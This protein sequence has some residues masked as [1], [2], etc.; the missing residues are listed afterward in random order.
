M[1]LGVWSVS[2]ITAL[3]KF[4]WGLSITLLETNLN[5]SFTIDKIN[6]TPTT[7]FIG[8][9]GQWQVTLLDFADDHAW[10]LL[11]KYKLLNI[12]DVCFQAYISV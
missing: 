5:L 4:F 11:I 2:N 10:S 1:S 3:L 9:L 7:L 8:Y 6:H 12:T